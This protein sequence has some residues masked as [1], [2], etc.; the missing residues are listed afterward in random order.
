MIK[1][2]IAEWRATMN[3]GK[4]VSKAHLAR[5]VHVSRSFV[6]KLEKGKAQPGA[7]L[8]LRVA[9]YLKQPVEAVFQLA[10]GVGT[11]PVFICPR[12][13]PSSQ[14]SVF[15]PVPAKPGRTQPATPP[16]RPAGTVSVKDRSPVGPAAKAVAPPVA[17]ASQ[18]QIQ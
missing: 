18:K 14:F 11:K 13:I 8:M 17:L 15:A 7:A 4:G 5:K 2:N 16:A 3:D 10:D 9:R 6:T 1:N 12:T